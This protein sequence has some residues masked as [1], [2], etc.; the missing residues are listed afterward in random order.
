MTVATK[1]IISRSLEKAQQI[2]NV[3]DNLSEV[4]AVADYT[5]RLP[6]WR[7]LLGEEYHISFN[8]VIESDLTTPFKEML[9]PKRQ[10]FHDNYYLRDHVSQEGE[11]A[12]EDWVLINALHEHITNENLIS[13]TVP[14]NFSDQVN[15]YNAKG[16]NSPK[17]SKA[18]VRLVGQDSEVVKW[19]TNK[20][21]KKL[22]KGVNKDYK[23]NL[24]IL[25]HHIS[26]MSYYAPFNWGGSRWLEGWNKTSCMDTIRNSGGEGIYQLVPSLFDSTL[27]IAWLS[28]A[29]DDT[30]E[31]R[32]L[33]RVLVRLCQVPNG[34]FIMIGMRNFFVSNET[35]LMLEE[36]LR[37]EFENF[38]TVNDIR[39]YGDYPTTRLEMEGLD[40][41][42]WEVRTK[43]MCEDCDGDGEDEDG[44][45]CYSCNGDG[46][47]HDYRKYLPYVD[48]S[49]LYNV[50][51]NRIEY[52]LPTS[53]LKS[54][55][56]VKSAKMSAQ[57]QLTL[58][59]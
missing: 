6:Y 44:D 5:E 22:E 36:G 58:A 16:Y 14:Q 21:P 29:D 35:R 26:G 27:A 33:S 24:S 59:C 53:F 42:Y 1:D 37:N 18:L 19:F 46:Y 17:L 25:P 39:K 32:Y 28:N 7:E 20:C 30:D 3:S 41:L 12:R 13:N 11:K 50:Y 49:D 31:P 23:V 10:E 54:K 2:L 52:R 56:Y 57:D 4:G 34:D 8:P 38:Y 40:D 48:D 15:Y 55:G 47:D 43:V 51:N 45:V 9:E